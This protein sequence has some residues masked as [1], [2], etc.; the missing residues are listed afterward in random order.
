MT[1][2]MSKI[3]NYRVIR[4]F[5]LRTTLLIPFVLQ[6]MTAVGVVGYL[7]F[8]N[9]Q[10]A[11]RDLANRLLEEKGN[12]IEQRILAYFEQPQALVKMTHAALQSESLNL[13]DLEKLHRYFWQVISQEKLGDYLYLG[14]SQGEFVGVERRDDG[15]IELR[16][17]SLDQAFERKTY[18]LD[19][20]GEPG[21]LI[22]SSDYD[23]RDRPWYQA[24]IK[25]RGLGW[26]PVFASFSRQNNSL[27]ISPIQPIFDSNGKVLAVIS[28]NLQ[29]VRI[30]D[31]LQS[32]SISEN[33]QSFIIERSG[34]LIASSALTEPFTILGEGEDRNIQRLAAIAAPDPIVR[35]TAKLLK[36]KF[37]DFA[38]IK[39]TQQLQLTLNNQRHY[40][41][42]LPLA[43]S[44]GINW[45]T[46]IIVPEIDFMAQIHKNTQNTIFLCLVA[47]AFAMAI[48][49]LT[50]R[51]ITRPVLR[52][53]RAANSFA[54]G[55][56]DQHILPHIIVEID[57]LASSFNRMAKQLKSSFQNLELKN[58][59]LRIA[60]ENYRSIFENALEG[61]FQSSPEGRFINVNS[62]LAK[63]Y[64]YDSSID[65]I[66]SVV[67]IGEQL[68]V[69]SEA[70][71]EFERLLDQQEAVKNFEY[72]SYCKDGKI[73]WTQIDARVVKDSSDQVLYYEG[74]VQ[75]I[76]ERKQRD[77]ELRRQLEELKIEIDQQKR[78]KEVAMLTESSY[79]Q[80]VQQEIANIDLDEFWGAP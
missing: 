55:N 6:I 12:R 61:I 26:S 68:Y 69:D 74:M 13:N 34:D 48:G 77:D 2:M 66:N 32:L 16:I 54:K 4:K 27:E 37:G 42:V 29:L 78:A 49:I 1:R 20:Q 70:R 8:R 43:D 76:T 35:Q 33:G 73:I 63:I 53:S 65:M 75:D 51:W 64:G 31:F 23:P 60:E 28:M 30:T 56:L 45:L 67:N 24:G 9:G 52:V 50:S 79:F 59:E 10:Q 58:E 40:I 57:T 25:L 19:D 14:T 15:Q 72:R 44:R 7:S 21:D 18:L 41:Q 46:V 3:T 5:R 47:L 38:S 39:T 17:R 11:V 22:S 80:E 36:Q 71:S 62:A